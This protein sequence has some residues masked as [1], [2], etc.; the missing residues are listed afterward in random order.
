MESDNSKS[1]YSAIGL[2]LRVAE[3]S[4]FG[5]RLLTFSNNPEWIN[6]DDCLDFVSAVKKIRKAPWGMNTNFIAALDLILNTAIEN[7]I[8][9]TTMGEMTLIIFSDMQ[10]D[11]TIKYNNFNNENNENNIFSIFERIKLKYEDAG[12]KSIFKQPYPIPHIIFWN[13]RN[14]NEFPNLS[15]TKNIS[16]LSG[17]NTNLLNLFLNKGQQI[18]KEITPWKL[19]QESLENKRYNDFNIL[20]LNL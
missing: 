14:T 7:N 15:E 10:I 4:N 9:P 2:G 3:K 13:L 20:K 6:L 19:L 11:S 18:L 1:L 17:S 12:N 8:T 5:K 16:M